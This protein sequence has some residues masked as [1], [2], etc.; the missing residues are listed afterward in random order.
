MVTV[1]Q[2]LS[3]LSAVRPDAFVKARDALA[4][5]LRKEGASSTAAAVVALKR[6]PVVV[7]AVNRLAR[8]AG[9]VVAELIESADR[10]KAAQLGR[11]SS[12]ST[13]TAA[14]AQQRSLLNDLMRR[15]EAL[16]GEAGVRS[17][18]GLLRRIETTLLAGASDKESRSAL[19]RGRLDR[20]LAPL[21]FDVFDGAA[22]ARRPFQEGGRPAEP[23]RSSP[24]PVAGPPL[25]TPTAAD[26]RAVERSVARAQAA[27]EARRQRIEARVQIETLRGA[28]SGAA[29]GVRQAREELKR[30]REALRASLRIEKEARHALAA[31]TRRR[32]NPGAA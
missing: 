9:D 2:A 1:E 11:G 10:V 25:R 23:P 13:L 30:A 32:P 15:A 22:P 19:R 26:R 6:P 20:E 29:S 17:T 16:L 12:A 3:E 28:L 14:T 5:R 8:E 27:E 21:G 31:A 7:W 24:A 4:A 18:A